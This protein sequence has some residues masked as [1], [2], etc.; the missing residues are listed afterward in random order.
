MG[1]SSDRNE[2]SASALFRAMAARATDALVP[3]W[4]F[5]RALGLI[6]FSAFYSLARQVHGLIGERGIIP[7]GAYLQQLR[8]ELPGIT[9]FWYAPSVFWLGSGDVALTAVVALG[10][11][12]SLLLVANVW[13]RA[14]TAICTLLFLSF[15]STLQVFSSYQSDGMLLEAGFISIWFAPGGFR[16]GLGALDPPSRFS[17]FMLRWEWFR[18]YFESGLV[19]LMSGDVHWRNLTAMDDYYQNGPLPA[20]PGWYVQQLP[21][22]FHAGTVVMTLFVE[23]AVVWA[24][25]LPRRFRLA[26][27]AIV[28]AL[29]I[30]IIATANYAFLNYL[31]LGLGVLLVDDVAVKWIVARVRAAS[32]LQIVTHERI[33][34]AAPHSRTRTLGEAF[35]LV[36]MFYATIWAFLARGAGG[37]FA[38][39]ER[40][41]EPFR[42]ANAYGLFATMTAA[43][44]EIEFQGSN[45]GGR[46]WT[47]YEFRYKPQDLTER[48]G[49][50]APYQP[51][52][53]WNLWFASLEPWQDSPWLV[54]T[55]ARLAEGSD[56]VLTLF[57]RDPFGGHP[58]A[59]VRAV[60]WQ[61][62]FTDS[63]T[64][65]AT[66]AWWKRKDLGVFTGV[67]ARDATGRMVFT[68][69]A[70]Q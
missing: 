58:P 24:L 70:G 54:S 4:I 65:R 66:G 22:W 47:A 28:S 50:Y 7:A 64:K 5:L 38:L 26:C 17:T 23:L 27:F 6:F 3:R 2:L 32:V 69:A 63:P 20:W 19:K 29:Q 45:D 67:V 14:M 43:R 13:P 52:F 8:D 42:I 57:R 37:I 59:M 51:R 60:A 46:T 56:E 34:V 31:V 21:H 11:V 44:F 9:R 49:I 55:Q 1:A 40:M 39:P 35:V 16:P 10:I 41:L 53:D 30:G 33:A 61:Y 12:C 25:F 15:I 36:W 68:A 48:P 18:I 62:W